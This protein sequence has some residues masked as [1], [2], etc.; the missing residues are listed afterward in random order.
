M[1]VPLALPRL[2]L[3]AMTFGQEAWGAGEREATAILDAYLERGPGLVD[4]AD[5]YADKQSEQIVGRALRGRRQRALVATKAGFPT[6][7]HPEAR[8]LGRAHLEQALEASLRRLGT[9][10]IDL[11][12]AHVWDRRTP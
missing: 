4:T 5:V 1:T 10:Y 2:C 6:G 11:F 8:G 3:G 9:D 12:Q 7:E